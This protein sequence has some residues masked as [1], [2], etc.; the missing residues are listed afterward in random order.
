MVSASVPRTSSVI[1]K[2]DLLKQF[3]LSLGDVFYINRLA[4]QAADMSQSGNAG[5]VKIGAC[6][7]TVNGN[8]Y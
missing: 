8:M 5:D 3:N 2:I 7:M 6:V 4:I 1:S